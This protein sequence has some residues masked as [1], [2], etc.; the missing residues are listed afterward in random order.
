[1]EGHC[2]QR[3]GNLPGVCFPGGDLPA[4]GTPQTGPEPTVVEG[5]GAADPA[6][7]SRDFCA[8]GA[9]SVAADLMFNTIEEIRNYGL[10]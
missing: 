8:H 10:L 4:S 7:Q 5:E 3:A 2:C 9:G 1:M 6:N